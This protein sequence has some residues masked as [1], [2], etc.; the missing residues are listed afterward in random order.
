MVSIS[1]PIPPTVWAVKGKDE[2]RGSE[3]GCFG[4]LVA[5][6]ARVSVVA[7]HDMHDRRVT[8]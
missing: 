2:W 3:S 7:G 8:M 6:Q 5:A 4:T 1:Q